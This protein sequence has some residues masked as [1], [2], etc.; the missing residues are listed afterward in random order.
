MKVI[1]LLFTLL[2][3]GQSFASLPYLHQFFPLNEGEPGIQMAI[4]NQITIPAGQ[5]SMTL[6]QGEQQDI[7]Y[8]W[9]LVFKNSSNQMRTLNKFEQ[10]EIVKATSYKEKCTRS[11]GVTYKKVKFKVNH[12]LI[13]Y[14]EYNSGAFFPSQ[15]ICNYRYDLTSDLTSRYSEIGIGA[16][17]LPVR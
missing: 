13:D 3:S 2:L 11:T 17:S 15:R 1:A 4:I 14:I 12:D 5:N 9:R 7:P 10:F 8:Q 6:F 16:L